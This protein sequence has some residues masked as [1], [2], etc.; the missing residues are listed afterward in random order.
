M[1]M[2]PACLLS[3]LATAEAPAASVELRRMRQMQRYDRQPRSTSTDYRVPSLNAYGALSTLSVLDERKEAFALPRGGGE[4]RSYRIQDT[5]V[6]MRS[7]GWM[8]FDLTVDMSSGGA[9]SM[10]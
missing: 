10:I 4:K 2:P 9:T 8:R 6:P 3:L 7:A 1:P 5:T